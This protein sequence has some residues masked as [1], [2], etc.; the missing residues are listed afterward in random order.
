M[1]P[2]LEK[3]ER[4]VWEEVR[5]EIKL[6]SYVDDIHLVI[7]DLGRRGAQLYDAQEERE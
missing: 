1:A 5:V 3:M 4:R 2:I 6:P 7:Y